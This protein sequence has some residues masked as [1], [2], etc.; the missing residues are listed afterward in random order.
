MRDLLT[1]RKKRPK[2]VITRETTHMYQ[3]SR[4]ASCKLIP[5][6]PRLLGLL[7]IVPGTMAYSLIIT[8][9]QTRMILRV[10]GRILTQKWSS[11]AMTRDEA[12]AVRKQ[13]ILAKEI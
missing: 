2:A 5:L 3:A 4:V 8:P 7:C 13:A 1:T 11:L 9:P 6:A 12:S 10:V